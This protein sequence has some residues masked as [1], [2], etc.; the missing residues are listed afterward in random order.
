MA[1]GLTVAPR[2]GRAAYGTGGP[3]PHQPRSVASALAHC[4][5]VAALAAAVRSWVGS[6]AVMG[7]R[8][9]LVL[10]VC[11]SLLPSWWTQRRPLG[12]PAKTRRSRAGSGGPGGLGMD[13][14]SSTSHGRPPSAMSLDLGPPP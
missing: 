3:G 2:T 8:L 5:K 14:P 7:G 6:G 13:A 10:R 12:L 1:A 4:E 11:E 9:R